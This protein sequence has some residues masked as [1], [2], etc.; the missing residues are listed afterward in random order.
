MKYVIIL[1]IFIISC[2][3]AQYDNSEIEKLP[4][5]T[6]SFSNTWQNICDNLTMLGVAIQEEPFNIQQ[7]THIR[8]KLA[9][10]IYSFSRISKNEQEKIFYDAVEPNI[11]EILTMVDEMITFASNQEQEKLN[12]QIYKIQISLEEIQMFL[13]EMSEK[14]DKI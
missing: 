4:V 3:S 5:H 14:S 8:N 1:A 13:K 6:N 9:D 11:K 10:E 2:S 7:L 12:I